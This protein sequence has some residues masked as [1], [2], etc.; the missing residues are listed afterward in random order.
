MAEASRGS[1]DGAPE[2]DRRDG[3]R[4]AAVARGGSR[5]RRPLRE[6]A[7]ADPDVSRWLSPAA[8]DRALAPENFLGSAP[9]FVERV[10]KQWEHVTMF[11]STD[12]GCRLNVI[13]GPQGSVPMVLSNSLGT[14]HSLWDFQVAAFSR[15]HAVWRYDTRGHGE[16]DKPRG[17][18]SID[19]L[20]KDLRGDH[21]RDRRRACRSLRRL[22]R[23]NDGAVGCPA[24]A[25]S[26]PH[27]WSSR[28]PPRRS[29]MTGM[30][31]ARIN[32]VR[33]DGL[34]RLADATMARWFTPEFRAARP[35][36]VARFHSTIAHIGRG[37]LCGLLCRAARCRSATRWLSRVACP[38][39]VVDR[40]ARSGNA[41]GAGPMA[42]GA[43]SA[44]R[45]LVELDAAHLVERRAVGGVQRGGAEFHDRRMR[46]SWTISN[47]TRKRPRNAPRRCLATRTSI[48]RLRRRRR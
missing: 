10:L 42:G 25:G 19:R 30:W 43:D 11:V 21:R 34:A 46:N 16:S 5:D 15:Q 12:D 24:R 45:R 18:Y 48:A 35:E 41:A 4:R 29:A 1:P 39:L 20:G 23:W 2:P 38:A 26:R 33:T 47:G 6:L 17:D 13:P 36:V 7:S 32:T 3:S 31:S 37:R 8:I 22:D 27:G 9:L 44:G 14:D 28:T 40:P